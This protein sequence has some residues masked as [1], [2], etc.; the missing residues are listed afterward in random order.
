MLNL[1][2]MEIL[3]ILVVALL[4]LGPDKLPNVMRTIGK[5]MGELRRVSTEFQR[6][7]HTE[8]ARTDAA[9]KTALAPEGESPAPG[10]AS[11]AP[12][13]SIPGASIP[14]LSSIPEAAALAHAGLRRSLPR[15]RKTAMT[16]A[17]RRTRPHTGT[18]AGQA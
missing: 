18:D 7:I 4:V 15:A 5:A 16:R 2:G 14:D 11:A 9:V 8:A 1:G 12:D 6:T 3:V 10:Q 13:A 17:A